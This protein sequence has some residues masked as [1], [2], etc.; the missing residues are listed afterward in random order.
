MTHQIRYLVTGAT[1]FIGP[2][3]IRELLSRGHFC[4][5]LVRDPKKLGIIESNNL[6]VFVGD[7]TRAET[8]NGVA[9]Q[10]DCVLHLATLGHMNNFTVLPEMF[11]AV[12]VH[13]AINI[14]NAALEAG[15]KRVV[16]CSSVAAMGIC[17]D[18]PATEESRCI[19]HH[20]YGKSKLKAEEAV[21]S[22]V[23]S[24]GLPA[25]I[26]RFSMV[27][28]PGDWRDMLKLTRLAKKGL[29]PKVGN[30]PKLTPLIHVDDAVQGILL[31]AEK[32]RIGET[33][34]ITNAESE[35]FD[36]LRKLI[37]ESLGIWRPSLFVPEKL[38]LGL[39]TMVESIFTRLGW[40]PPVSHKNIESTL[41]DRV[42]SIRKAE[43]ELGFRPTIDPA[44]GIRQTVEWYKSKGWV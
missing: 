7:I 6:E 10:I 16:H 28:G 33:Y 26:I 5:C 43:K 22:M 18:N 11:E 15:V 44:A 20:P 8:L 42:F 19:P 21:R 37:L 29:F 40:A 31:A 34:L 17:A 4:R 12:N 32:G 30:R 13:G 3:L 27:Y 25:C 36:R 39:A 41:A 35:P 38:A 9:R 2:H 24:H 23:A 14:M 1:G